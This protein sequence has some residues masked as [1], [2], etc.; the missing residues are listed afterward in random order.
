MFMFLV[1][2]ETTLFYHNLDFRHDK[3]SSSGL[4]ANWS[5]KVGKTRPNIVPLEVI[6]GPSSTVI[7]SCKSVK[8]KKVGDRG[9]DVSLTD[10][11]FNESDLE[12]L[13]I[14]KTKTEDAVSNTIFFYR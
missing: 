13:P 14:R 11:E 2:A 6:S 9:Y 12:Y 4:I 7:L 3:V 8:L 1:L 5:T 10:F